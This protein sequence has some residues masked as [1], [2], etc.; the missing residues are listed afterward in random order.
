AKY[1]GTLAARTSNGRV[2]STDPA[3]I[4]L[5]NPGYTRDLEW[6]R[7]RVDLEMK[8]DGSLTGYVG[9]YR[10]GEP[11]YKGCVNARGPV[12]NVL[13]CVPWPTVYYALRRSRDFR[14]TGPA[15][16]KT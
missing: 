15:G 12:I 8:P 13:T 6:L 7:A 14:P 5:R 10:P 2:I 9:G 4:M 11:V 16:E 1:E 3:D